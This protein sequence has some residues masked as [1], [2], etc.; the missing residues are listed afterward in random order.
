[1]INYTEEQ[2]NAINYFNSNLLL[3]ASAGSGKTQV[4]LEKVIKLIESGV[5]LSEILMVTF[6]NLAASEMKS[7]LENML[8]IK[9]SENCSNNFFDAI[10]KI[11]A[12]DI[13]TLH[14]FCQKLVRE[15]YYFLGI[16]PTFEIC[17]EVLSFKFKNLALKNTI[18]YYLDKHD[19]E[20]INVSNLFVYKRDYSLF[21]EEILKFYEF[22]IS[23]PNK[24]DFIEN[25]IEKNYNTNFNE[26][27]LF[28]KY[29]IFI[30]EKLESLKEEL[31]K[32]IISA[33]QIGS[34]KLE[35]LARNFYYK[36]DIDFKDNINFIDFCKQKI[37]FETIRI[38][39]NA[40]VEEVQL[41]EDLQ[42]LAKKIK[43][44]ISN[45][46]NNFEIESNDDLKLNI[47]Q[48]EKVL[49]KLIEIIKKY[50]ENFLLAKRQNNCLDFSDL[51]VLTLKLFENETLLE[52]IS[53][54]YKYVFVDEYQ[55]TNSIQE[56]I[57][58][59]IS[60]FSTRVMVGDLK[61]SIY[62]FRECNPKIFN[63]KL[64]DYSN[65]KNGK[66]ILLN[67][68][69]RS[70]KTILD[71][72]NTIFSNL[73]REENCNYSYIKSGMFVAGQNLVNKNEKL[74]SVEVFCINK[75]EQ[76]NLEENNEENTIKNSKNKNTENFLI[77]NSVYNLLNEK[78]VENNVERNLEFKDIAII[79]RKRSAK[80]KELCNLF[81]EYKIPYSFKFNE[82]IYKSFE[83]KL[84]LS[85]L[86]ILN[87]LDNDISLFSV[88]KNIYNFTSNEMLTIKTT[89]LCE[90]L[91]NYSKKDEILLK[92]NKF[93]ND[94]NN[95]RQEMGELSV[96]D[97]IKLIIKKL[98]L[99]LI[100]LKLNGKLALER[101]NVFLSSVSTKIYSVSEFLNFAEESL[102][103]NFEVKKVTSENAITIDTFHST[104][105]LEYNAV[106]VTGAGDSI[107]AKNNSN[108]IYNA[109]LGVGIYDFNLE[110]KTKKPNVVFNMIKQ[111]NKQQEFNE[112]VRLLY[113]ALTRAKHFMVILGTEKVENLKEE[114]VASKFL[115]LNSYLSLICAQKIDDPNI[116]ITFINP[117][118]VLLE[119]NLAC[120]EYEF[121]ELDF[122]V[123][124]QIENSK[125]EYENSTHLQL[126]N[127]VTS[128]SEDDKPIYNIS[129]FKVTDLDEED[130]LEIGNAYHLV[131]EKLPLN[132]KTTKEVKNK[133]FEL[134]ENKKL[135][136]NI[137]EFI[138]DD[139]ILKAIS[140][141]SPLVLEG[142]KVY[143][144]HNFMLYA[145]HCE[146]TN[147]TLQD[148]V[149]VQGI[150]DL[151]IEKENEII[152]IDYKTSRLNNYN[153]IKR[154][155]TQLNLY[156][157]ALREKYKNKK[158]K[159]YI[160]SIFLDNLI[161]IV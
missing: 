46:N 138:N 140:Q 37:E 133:I 132:L 25:L 88:L 13:C 97:L 60:K 34:E 41:K 135:P 43:F 20:F 151:F 12:S 28:T 14:S 98:D 150:I 139:K 86:K 79:S 90:S 105:G 126:K 82:K 136:A 8:I 122:S 15:Y 128:L 31:N 102:D 3:S 24:F 27:E 83:V 1:M 26:N 161:N 134:I 127:S 74:K 11:N 120:E 70:N 51:E 124:K 143:K 9:Q 101:I 33:K 76:K 115:E 112:E 89:T 146:I 100:L 36:I 85:Y 148:K 160:Y 99:D 152:L 53:K 117:S 6:T 61:Q 142:D 52:E 64:I 145:K 77:L 57:L 48:S 149:L 123:L 7:K 30:K 73:M 125:Y 62:A 144:E 32:I 130:Y 59:K 54:K 66:V 147:S 18:K 22:L 110:D 47:K 29:R 39:K 158:I 75:N 119:A 69:F 19:E 111:L 44:L 106:I 109:S 155:S 21:K 45:L 17:D 87:N 49:L 72:S 42:S 157:K 67:K 2:L 153:L 63:N 131:L 129:N 58:T 118:E 93:F 50:E 159:K 91:L 81:D 56:E 10:N 40:T 116:K 68:N 95:I 96:K 35:G 16:E 23:K 55:D 113:V 107:F 92:I 80:L 108:L 121:K 94:Y 4:L 84:I 103:K 65:E 38:K 137:Y 154:Y 5:D 156:E 71:F 141:I 78:I 114:K 104:K